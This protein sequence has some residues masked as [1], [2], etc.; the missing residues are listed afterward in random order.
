MNAFVLM[1][2]GIAKQ[3][4][5]AFVHVRFLTVNSNLSPCSLWLL[6]FCQRA[7]AGYQFL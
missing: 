1:R 5:D 4:Q 6:P 3:R 2:A 7:D